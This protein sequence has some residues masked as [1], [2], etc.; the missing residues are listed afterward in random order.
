[1]CDEG[2]SLSGKRFTSLPQTMPSIHIFSTVLRCCVVK[3]LRGRFKPPRRQNEIMIR[4]SSTRTHLEFIKSSRVCLDVPYR[5]QDCHRHLKF[6]PAF[7]LGSGGA[8]RVCC[9]GRCGLRLPAGAGWE[10]GG[11][12]GV[13]V[14]C[15]EKLGIYMS[16]KQ[17]E[18]QRDKPLKVRSFLHIYSGLIIKQY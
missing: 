5:L 15:R 11:G 14:G 3:H 4:G 10:T 12:D 17:M 18:T 13:T 16:A 2:Q 9:A 1:M 7:L 8:V 6:C